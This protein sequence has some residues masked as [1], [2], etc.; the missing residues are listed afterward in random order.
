MYFQSHYK[1]SQRN[2][3]MHS[4]AHPL[5]TTHAVVKLYHLNTYTRP[6]LTSKE[7]AIRRSY[8]TVN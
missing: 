2:N 8:D 4:K 5:L 3:Q 7:L 1:S 6:L